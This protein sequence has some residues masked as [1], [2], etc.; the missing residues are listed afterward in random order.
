MLAS[1]FDEIVRRHA[2]WIDWRRQWSHVVEC[3]SL[4]EIEI[5]Q[6]PT[7]LLAPGVVTVRIFDTVH[8]RGSVSHDPADAIRCRELID[9]LCQRSSEAFPSTTL[10]L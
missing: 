2:R 5:Q 8:H 3:R 6:V 9:T 10:G 4:E 1:T 7:L